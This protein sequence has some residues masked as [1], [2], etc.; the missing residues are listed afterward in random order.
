MREARRLEGKD[1]LLVSELQSIGLTGQ[2][3]RVGSIEI[4]ARGSQA[5]TASGDLPNDFQ[6]YGSCPES[7]AANEG[8]AMAEIIH[9]LAPL[10]SLAVAQTSVLGFHR[11]YRYFDY[12]LWRRHYCR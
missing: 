6:I 1:L 2:G 5:A 7:C 3:V 9:D 11:K 4:S 10:A 12:R 8:T